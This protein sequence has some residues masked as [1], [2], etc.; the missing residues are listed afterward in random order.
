MN[1]EFWNIFPVSSRGFFGRIPVGIVA[2][3]IGRNLQTEGE[4][5]SGITEQL[6]LKFFRFIL[7]W[8]FMKILLEL[9]KCK[10]STIPSR[11]KNIV[12]HVE[13]KFYTQ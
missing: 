2:S 12:A 7:L 8:N 6:I 1:L 5:I 4:I 11:L 9:L 13:I 3:P 10:K